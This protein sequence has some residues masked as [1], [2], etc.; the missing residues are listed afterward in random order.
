MQ[1]IKD[2]VV[3]NEQRI[4]VSPRDLVIID[5]F[6]GTPT[7]DFIL[8]NGEDHGFFKLVLSSE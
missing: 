7:P 2:G 4:T 8:A 3:I 6:N 1:L 5:K